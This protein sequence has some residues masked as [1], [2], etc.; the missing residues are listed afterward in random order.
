[1]VTREHQWRLGAAPPDALLGHQ[2]V[3]LVI[4]A[5]VVR[6]RPDASLDRATGAIQRLDVS[7]DLETGLRGL[8][9]DEPDLIGR[10]APGLAVDADLDDPRAEELVLPN[11]F[12]DLVRRVGVEILGIDDLAVDRHFRRRPELPAQSADDESR[13][14]DRRTGDPAL[15]DR[16]AQ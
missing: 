7:L 14:D 13:V 10:V 9:D 4:E 12:H 11:G 5:I 2:L 16:L 15:F 6:D 1:G 3:H 8:A